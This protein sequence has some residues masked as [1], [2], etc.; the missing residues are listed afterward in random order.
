M[1]RAVDLNVHEEDE[2]YRSVAAL[3]GQLDP[4]GVELARMHELLEQLQHHPGWAVLRRLLLLEREA[5]VRKL[6]GA[7]VL[8]HAEYGYKAGQV[9]GL[10]GPFGVI[11]L[12]RSTNSRLQAALDKAHAAEERRNGEAG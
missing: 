2:G 1:M 8:E 9:R 6:C 3:L 4:D 7:K 12:V 5:A 10:A 11:E